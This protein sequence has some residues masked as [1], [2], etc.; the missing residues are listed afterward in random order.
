MKLYMK[1]TPLMDAVDENS[2]EKVKKLIE[3]GHDIHE[4]NEGAMFNACEKNNKEILNYLIENGADIHCEGDNLLNCAAAYGHHDMINFLLEKGLDIHTERDYPLVSALA[5]KKYDTVLFLLEKG[6]S[7]IRY[8][9]LVKEFN[10]QIPEKYETAILSFIDS[11]QYSLTYKKCTTNE[12]NNIE[13]EIN[14]LKMIIS[15]DIKRYLDIISKL[16]LK[17]N[18]LENES[19]V[20][21][22]TSNIKK[23]TISNTISSLSE[24]L[25]S[26]K[27]QI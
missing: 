20:D 1:I 15:K 3:E 4:E 11:Q 27:T 25:K 2:F 13:S 7:Y 16:N 24:L 17:I 19:N 6:A 8:L 10:L 26:V 14:L 5:S 9:T 12:L 18:Y 23:E 22:S 21:S